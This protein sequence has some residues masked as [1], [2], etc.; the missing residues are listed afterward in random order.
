MVTPLH[1][2]HTHAHT[3]TR[4]P[5]WPH[6]ITDHLDLGVLKAIRMAKLLFH[7]FTNARTAKHTHIQKDTHIHTHTHRYMHT[8]A[9]RLFDMPLRG[10][11]RITLG[12][13]RRN[14]Y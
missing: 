3:Y 4:S 7:T 10:T 12:R 9:H 8:Q 6:G 14:I 11:F 5:V 2:A 13:R 1:H